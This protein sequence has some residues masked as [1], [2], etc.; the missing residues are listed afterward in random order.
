MLMYQSFR[1]IE[2]TSKLA[3]SII[4]LTNTYIGISTHFIGLHDHYLCNFS[5]IFPCESYIV[6]LNKL[7]LNTCR[8]LKIKIKLVIQIVQINKAHKLI[9]K[10]GN[11]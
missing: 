8:V 7:K 10:W 11:E 5:W 4:D 1:I 9:S 6:L 2:K 3:D